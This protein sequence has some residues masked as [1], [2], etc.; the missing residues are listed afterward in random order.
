[1]LLYADRAETIPFIETAQG[2]EYRLASLTHRLAQKDRKTIGFLTG[3]R[4]PEIEYGIFKAALSEEFNTRDVASTD[5]GA[6]DLTGVDVVVVASPTKGIPEK[7][8]ATL[9]GYLAAGGKA[10][11]LLE[12]VIVD[13][14][15]LTARANADSFADFALRYGVQ[16]NQDLVYDLRANETVTFGSGGRTFLLPYPFWA[17]ALVQ[18]PTILGSMETVLVPWP[19]SLQVQEAAT[20]EMEI[21]PLLV[22]TLFAGLQ[23]DSFLLRPSGDQPPG[24]PEGEVLL[25]VALQRPAGSGPSATRDAASGFRI[26]II[27]DADW[28][29]DQA[30]RQSSG[31]LL[32]GLNLIDWLAQEDSL[33]R[34]RT[35]GTGTRM[36]FFGSSTHQSV[37]RFG[38]IL[39]VPVLLILAGLTRYSVRQ[40]ST[41]RVYRRAA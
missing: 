28:L 36:L 18:D 2:L 8:R 35:K 22:T 41:R 24:P 5:D 21:T 38:N 11:M 16:V 40:R 1:A 13:P 23:R 3:Y 37:V 26:A 19:S 7:A 9:S 12:P 10:L 29:T 15:T 6:L 34:I 33:V 31:N 17:R 27:G 32:A 4:E 20:R 30:I 25:G 14:T 39:G